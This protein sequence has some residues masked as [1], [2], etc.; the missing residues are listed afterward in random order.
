MNLPT[1]CTFCLHGYS[2]DT[3]GNSK[4]LGRF[5]S[6]FPLAGTGVPHQYGKIDNSASVFLT[7]PLLSSLPVLRVVSVE[8]T[9]NSSAWTTLSSASI[10]GE[11]GVSI[12]ILP[13]NLANLTNSTANSNCSLSV[14]SGVVAFCQRTATSQL[15][16]KR[17]FCPGFGWC[18][19]L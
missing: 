15:L 12:L 1:L 14:V 6:A 10:P 18:C 16:L 5:R 9:S 19:L 13:H 17:G 7:S 11:E 8:A 4:P 3:M 2:V